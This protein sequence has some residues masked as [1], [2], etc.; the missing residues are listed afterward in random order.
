M[1][2]IL[3]YPSNLPG[4]PMERHESSGVTVEQ[5]LYA[6][7]EGYEPRDVP[8]IS[9]AVDGHVV[10]PCA[11]SATRIDRDSCVEIRPQPKGGPELLIAAVVAGV[12]AVAATLLLKPSMPSQ[13]NQSSQRGRELLEVTAEGNQPKLG[14]VIPEQAGRYRRMPDYLTA[15]RRYFVDKRNQALDILLC[16]GKGQFSRDGMEI[17]IG[18]TPIESLG[19]DVDYQVFDPGENV[20]GHQAHRNWFNAPEVGP[21]TGSSGLRLNRGNVV[22]PALNAG[23]ANFSG[24]AIT[25]PSGS[26]TIPQNWETGFR[27]IVDLF[28][29]V[30]VIDGGQDENDNYLRDILQGDFS[31]LSDG[32]AITIRGDTAIDGNY[33]INEI[34]SG[35]P[36]GMTLDSTGGEPQAFLEPDEYSVAVDITGVRYII[37]AIIQYWQVSFSDVAQTI[38][39]NEGG[40][41]GLNIEIGDTIEVFGTPNAG[42]YGVLNITATEIEVDGSLSELTNVT[43]GIANITKGNYGSDESYTTRRGLIVS[44]TNPDGSIDTGWSGFAEGSTSDF[45][46]SVDTDDLNSDW[47]GPYLACPENETTSRIE[48]D[49]FAPSG[50]GRIAD[51]GA[52]LSR[53]RNVELQYRNYGDT[54]WTSVTET[55]I[56]QSRDQLGWTFSTNFGSQMTPE[57]RLRRTSQEDTST[58]SLDKLEW[59]GLRSR[60]PDKTSYEGVTTLAMTVYGSDTIAS[61]TENQISVV[62]TRMLPVRDGDGWTEP[63]A[64]RDIAPWF[65]YIAKSVGYTDDELDLDELERLDDTWQARGD[66]FDFVTKDDS[67]VKE[68]INRCLRAGMAELT[69]DAGRLRPARDEPR[70]EIEHPYS[71]QNMLSPP[72]RKAQ[73]PRPDDADGV[74]VEF[75][76]SD[77]WTEETVECRLPGDQGVRAEKVTLE[78]VTSRTRAWR[79]GMRRRRELKYRRWEYDFATELDALNSRYLSYDAVI[80]DVPGYGQSSILQMV[81]DEGEQYLLVVSE[82]MD[83]GSDADHVVA[84]RRPDGTLAGPFPAEPGADDYQILAAHDGDPV[85]EIDPQ[86]EPPHVYFG[87]IERWRFPVL[88]QAISPR[89]FERVNVTA[90]NYDARVYDDD[91]NVPD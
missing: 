31:G 39:A 87:T 4:E 61:Q 23:A 54:A 67:T 34:V 6:H 69:I 35:D 83:W 65:A 3:V 58:Q 20:S 2:Q 14:D 85:P 80:D 18:S 57:V 22:T 47:L 42:Q 81:A 13:R 29:D 10:P 33:V 73:A 15:P 59:Y 8:P 44:R 17:R 45:E 56:G 55:L 11:W 49:I 66:F 7:V 51:D 12:A 62:S 36:D 91:N 50:L 70:E 89:G 38:S 19:E 53:S 30:I 27:L 48:W 24:Q 63:Q 41:A 46:I 64:T 40:F 25:L 82:P 26:G 37:D 78:G 5:W 43:A 52:I 76:S 75:V 68:S 72:T 88:V 32:D 77:S 86:K 16:I 79:I 9:I 21:S 84:W 71:Q 1:G 60:L 90:I 28:A 74:D